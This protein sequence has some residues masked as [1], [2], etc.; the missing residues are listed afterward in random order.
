[1]MKKF[2]YIMVSLLISTALLAQ[3]VND[4]AC[5]AIMLTLGADCS[6]DL[7]YDN[8]DATS[9]TGEMIGIVM[10]MDQLTKQFGFPS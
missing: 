2:Y 5:N 1:M 6:R 3:P 10:L 8:T 7:P 9:Q 4:S